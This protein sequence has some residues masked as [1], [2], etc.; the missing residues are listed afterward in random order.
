MLF[1]LENCVGYDIKLSPLKAVLEIFGKWPFGGGRV[2]VVVAGRVVVCAVQ[3]EN[4]HLFWIRWRFQVMAGFRR[5]EIRDGKAP[6]FAQ[7]KSG[8]KFIHKNQ[9]TA[10]FLA[11]SK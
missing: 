5:W 2:V 6:P 7:Q 8:D 10:R 1:C 11:F 4:R 3:V 9:P